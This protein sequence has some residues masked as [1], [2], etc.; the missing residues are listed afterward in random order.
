MI[1]LDDIS[2]VHDILL[3]KQQLQSY[4]NDKAIEVLNPDL[5]NLLYLLRDNSAND[6]T[7][8]QGVKERLSSQ[9]NVLIRL[10]RNL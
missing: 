9:S 5:K 10:F 2:I 8:I 7:T 3:N 1:I 6:V 4:Y